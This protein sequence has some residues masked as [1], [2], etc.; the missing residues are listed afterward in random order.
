MFGHGRKDGIS[1]NKTIRSSYN[2]LKNGRKVSPLPFLQTVFMQHSCASKRFIFTLSNLLLN[3]DKY[4]YNVLH[5][6]WKYDG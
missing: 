2:R 5:T 3:S 4:R 1:V 6:L